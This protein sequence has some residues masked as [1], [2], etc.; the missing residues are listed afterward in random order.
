MEPGAHIKWCARAARRR[1][2]VH[3]Y[4]SLTDGRLQQNSREG[5][6]CTPV[7]ECW[8]IGR[9]DQP[10]QPLGRTDVNQP[11]GDHGNSV[12][13]PAVLF[14]CLCYY[15]LWWGI[16]GQ[17]DPLSRTIGKF[18][19]TILGER[20]HFVL[21]QRLNDFVDRAIRPRCGAAREEQEQ[22]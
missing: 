20:L 4:D 3:Q 10:V 1:G 22:R 2:E 6:A 21:L 13:S 15:L 17:N 5:C 8:Q 12:C 16:G 11:C 9:A 19:I 7:K 18:L 14:D